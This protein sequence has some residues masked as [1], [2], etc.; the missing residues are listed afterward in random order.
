MDKIPLD[1]KAMQELAAG[2]NIMGGAIVHND[3]ALRAQV[4]TLAALVQE[5]ML[6]SEATDTIWKDDADRV[7]KNLKKDEIDNANARFN[8]GNGFSMPPVHVSNP[9]EAQNLLSAGVIPNLN[10]SDKHQLAKIEQ[11]LNTME[12]GFGEEMDE[13]TLARHFGEQPPKPSADRLKKPIEKM[14]TLQEIKDWEAEQDNSNDIYKISARIKNLARGDAGHSLG[15]QQ[16][17]LCNSFC[18]V[19]KAFYDFADTLPKE[20]KQRLVLLTRQQESVPATI[21]AA[22]VAGV[23]GK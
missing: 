3:M 16:E 7:L 23:K 18:H 19:V 2:L 4:K 20:L 22:A 9:H 1:E 11:E 15:P 10:T 12:A 6:F 17:S 13:A 14:S 8:K 21:I 5:A